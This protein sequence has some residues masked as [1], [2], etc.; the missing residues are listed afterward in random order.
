MEDQVLEPEE[1]RSIRERLGLT[2]AEA[3]KLLGGGP[4]AFS[5]YEGG[6]VKPSA[7]VVSLL[8][9]LEAN[10]GAIATLQ[11]RRSRPMPAAS[12]LPFQVSGQ[13]IAV[14]PQGELPELLRLLLSA[15]A[16]TYVLPADGIHVASTL[17]APDGGEDG[18]IEW[19][20]GRRIEWQSG[21]ERTFFLPSRLC[22]FQLKA[23]QIFPAEAGRDVL[24]EGGKVKQM[25][26]QVVADGGHYRMLCP[27]PYTQ[28][29][30]E[31]R[32]TKIREVLRKAGMTLDDDQIDFRDGDQ[33]ASWVNHHPSV[34]SWLLEHVQLGLRG[35][36]H[37]WYHWAGR[38]EHKNSPWIE[39]ERLPDL[40]TFLRKQVTAPRTITRLVGLAGVGKS[41]LALEALRLTDEDD[42]IGYSPS[43]L[44]L[45]AVA[46]EASPAAVSTAVQNLA[47]SGTRAIAVIDCCAPE[48]QRIL[49]GMVSRDSSRVSL[50]TIHDEIP[51]GQLDQTT[52]KVAEAPS[53]VTEAIINRSLPALGSEDR[54]RLVR[55]S[56]GFPQ[57]AIRSSQLWAESAPLVDAIDDDLVDAFVL[58][59]N[60][61]DR[62]LLL[63]SA[64]L[65]ATFGLVGNEPPL[66]GEL[67]ELASLTD[68]LTPDSLHPAAQELARRGVVQQRG[69]YVSLEPRPIAMKLATGQWQR[70]RQD[71]WDR[72]LAGDVSLKVLAARQLALLN[73]TN[74]SREVVRHVCR[75]D[76]PFA[77][78]KGLSQPGHAEVLSHLAEVDGQ[79]V[80]T[81]IKMSSAGR[82]A[83][84]YQG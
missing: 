60:P 6:T 11:G 81:Q 77:G 38:A 34:A 41:R 22:Q 47:D 42:A 74:I 61:R 33:I 20:A 63:K 56:R 76:G 37:S 7:A 9:V 50:V 59:H 43:D 13:H 55:F 48:L 23:G 51:A 15:E 39:D 79:V 66:D 36:F 27:H 62:D 31:A 40:S 24:T 17:Q 21:L 44:V 71:I 30:I 29:Q 84:G 32:E 5:K 46:S 57:V 83:R 58:G 2:Q 82:A 45:Y 69:R 52:F 64:A 18:R 4:R 26:R 8:R 12:L 73:T 54:H 14:L 80:L 3:G 10:P 25:V 19:K 28:K 75:F 53:P 65:L 49:A 35:P 78:L 68:G 67:S 1:V 16:Y 72:V 70:W